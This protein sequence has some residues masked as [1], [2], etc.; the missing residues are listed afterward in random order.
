MKRATTAFEITLMAIASI[1]GVTLM[2]H[3]YITFN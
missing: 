2:I 1:A 3:H